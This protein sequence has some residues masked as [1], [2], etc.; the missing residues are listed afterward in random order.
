MRTE[1]EVQEMIDAIKALRKR[2]EIR[3]NDILYQTM[4]NAL[5]WILNKETIK[6]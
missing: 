5:E 4:L 3:D 1:K 2:N 6:L